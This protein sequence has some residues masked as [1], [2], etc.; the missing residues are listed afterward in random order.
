MTAWV[1]A[2]TWAVL[3]L[4]LLLPADT[5]PW[6]VSLL[7]LVLSAIAIRSRSLRPFVALLATTLTLGMLSLL[8][9]GSANHSSSMTRLTT[10][11]QVTEANFVVLEPVR[12]MNSGNFASTGV[13]TVIRVT[14]INGRAT[15]SLGQLSADEKFAAAEVGEAY[16]GRLFFKPP[17]GSLRYGF[18]ARLEGAP[19]LLKQ[20]D[21]IRQAANGI[22]SL[23]LENSTGI[24]GDARGLVA[25]LTI[26]D[27]SLLSTEIQEQMK[28]VGLTHLTAVSGANCAIIAG[29]VMILLRRIRLSRF[30]RFGL[31]SSCLVGYLL[32]VGQQ[33]SVLRASVMALI[34]VANSALGRKASAVNA[35][36]LA[37]IVLLIADPWL[38]LEFGFALSAAATFGILILAPAT[39]LKLNPFMPKYL[40][41]ALSVSI[42]AQVMCLPILLQLQPGLSTY[43]LIANLLAEP[44]VAPVTVMGIIGCALVPFAPWL[45]RALSWL[46]SLAT[47]LI[48]NTARIL[49]GEPTPTLKWFSGGFGV[50]ASLVLIVAVIAWLRASEARVRLTGLLAALACCAAV[51]GLNA[52]GFVRTSSW[53]GSDWMIASCDVGQGDAIVLQSRGVTALI[54]TGK[55]NALIDACLNRLR[56]KRIDL[57]VL[58]HFDQDHVAGLAGALQRRSVG[59][60]LISP[61]EDQRPAASD[62]IRALNR[63]GVT[64]AFASRGMS[65]SLGDFTWRVLSPEP[66]AA[67]AENSNDASITMFWH[68]DRV[69]MLTMADLGASGQDRLLSA[70]SSILPSITSSRPLIMKVSHHGSADQSQEFIEAV[71][72]DIALVSVGS[73]N[74]YGHPTQKTLALLNRVGSQTLRTDEMG[75]IAL[76]LSNLGL[77]AVSSGQG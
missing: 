68:S 19:E 51:F 29:L 39:S 58:T 57:L 1:A 35:L 14:E 59:Q 25:G 21:A 22:R 44:L 50:L 60:A 53:P 12:K 48:E 70:N 9:Q 24:S 43:S 33:P 5:R 56:V 34:V 64:P 69:A 30:A 62:S 8:I 55:D 38:A 2:A 26:G 37:V 54:D 6:S 23:F 42:G 32:L 11:Y 15:N 45:T 7:A 36:G 52:S 61:F 17:S 41:L 47:W 40:A 28:V 20:P 3:A 10:D 63:I 65:G 49:A 76:Q 74:S 4:E 18:D 16:R 31:I 67:F 13:R 27:T 73:G 75:S 71:H 77:R 72:P 66:K 46:S